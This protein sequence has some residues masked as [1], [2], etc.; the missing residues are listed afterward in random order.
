M[1][2]VNVRFRIVDFGL[3]PSPCPFPF[4]GDGQGEG[5]SPIRNPHSRILLQVQ[6]VE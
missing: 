3:S 5:Q 6:V 1:T 2:P 4:W